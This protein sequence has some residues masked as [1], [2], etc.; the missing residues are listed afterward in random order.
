L[1]ANTGF[2]FSFQ[3]IDTFRRNRNQALHISPFDAGLRFS[4]MPHSTNAVFRV[5]RIEKS[6]GA[7][8]KSPARR[9]GQTSRQLERKF[10][11]AL[12][13]VFPFNRPQGVTGAIGVRYM[14]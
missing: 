11:W 14:G 7:A 8:D 5:E 13:K 2:F 12:K 10:D 9:R 6:G 3:L 4:G 1:V